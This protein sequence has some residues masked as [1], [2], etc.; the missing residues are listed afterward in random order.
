MSES[1]AGAGQPA[2]PGRVD[3]GVAA[4]PA[5]H[6]LAEQF[7]LESSPLISRSA[8]STR[9]RDSGVNATRASRSCPPA[10]KQIAHPDLHARA[11]EHGVDLALQVRA[12]PDQLGAVTHPATQLPR[13]GWRDPRL[14]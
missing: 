3:P 6:Q 10:L 5:G 2:G 1:S 14:G 9:A 8:E 12:Q 13:R 7:D 11:G 4:Q